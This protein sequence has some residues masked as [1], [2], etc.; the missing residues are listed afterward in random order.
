MTLATR[1]RLRKERRRRGARDFRHLDKSDYVLFSPGNSG[2]TWLRSMLTRAIELHYSLESGPLIQYDNLYKIDDRAPRI[3]VTHNRWLGYY[4]KPRPGSECK[5]YYPK[6][7]LILVR[8]PLDTCI[9][10][11]FQWLNRSKDKDIMLKGWPPKSADQGLQHFLLQPD[12]G[13]ERLCG[14]LNTWLEESAKFHRALFVRYEDMLE[15]PVAHLA[16]ALS[17]LDI[18]ASAQVIEESVSFSSF[19]NMRKRETN[20]P[21]TQVTDTSGQAA[22]GSQDGF[23]A[24]RGGVGG[25]SKY[26]SDEECSRFEKV[27]AEQLSNAFGYSELPSI[28]PLTPP[29][30][31][32][33]RQS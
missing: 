24:R 21:T 22:T 23:K 27:I 2:R 11:Y 16:D 14:E 12:T 29:A 26:L 6:A 13:V 1:Y 15:D 19:E 7:V 20:S 18:N 30:V 25:Y 33:H 17:F 9:S 3:T 28:L 8:N 10:Q 4:R 32:S 31:F 5:P